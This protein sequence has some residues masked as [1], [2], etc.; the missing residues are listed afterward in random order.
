VRRAEDLA[1]PAPKEQ[2]L[3][4]LAAAFESRFGRPPR[5]VV[6]APGRVNLIGEHLDYNEGH[7]LPVAID[8]SIMVAFAPRPDGRVRLH[9]VDFEQESAFDLEDIQRDPEA[10]WSDYVRGVAWAL[11]GAGHGVSG[12][13]AAI[14]GDVPVGAGLSSSAALE[15]AALGAFEAGSGFQLD[16]RD[17]AL[18]GQRAENGFVGVACGIM[19]QMAAALSRAGHAL[20]ID[21]RSLQYEAVPL[22]LAAVRLV[23]ADSGVRRSLL[24]SQ[25]NLRRQECQRAAEL[26]AAA[27]TDRPVTALRDVQ[28]ED[29]ARHGDALPPKLLKRARHVVEEERRVLLGV[30]VLR[31]GDVE[32][33]GEMLDAS[34]RSLRDDYEVSS[35][36]LDL[37]VELAWAQPG[38]LGSRLTG[39]GF[40]GCTVS[41]VRAEALESFR[42]GVMARYCRETGR[43]GRMYVCRAADGLTVHR[44]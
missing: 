42:E 7:V 24:D 18:L 19:D 27:I 12:L 31:A 1:A 6:A 39:A 43:E 4:R 34:H 25:Y 38:V 35:P 21:C 40:G 44:L 23:V 33:F 3:R 13:D 36:E 10:P 20:L 32:A 2:R 41:L 8:R 5:A 16:R 29:L 22:P 9:S 15:V 14:Q 17:L 26:L 28:P 11:R 37:L 30:E